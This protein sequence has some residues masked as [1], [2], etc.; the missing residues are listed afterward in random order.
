[1]YFF[2]V[3]VVVCENVGQ[4]RV[5]TSMTVVLCVCQKYGESSVKKKREG[6][7]EAE[8]AA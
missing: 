3:C 6:K 5:R 8:A 4:N 1:M 2:C 7:E